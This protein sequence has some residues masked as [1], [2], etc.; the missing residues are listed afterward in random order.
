MGKTILCVDDSVTMQ[1]VC[2]ITFRASDFDYVGARSAAEALDKARAAKP[3]LALVDNVMPDQSG[4]ELCEALK[5]EHPD[6]PVVL[7]CGNSE[8][9]DDV[10]GRRAGVDGHVTKPWDTT[11]LLEQIGEILERVARDGVARPGEDAAAPAATAGAPA[12]ASPAVAAS[13]APA[14]P[15]PASPAPAA[16]APP[17]A[18]PKPA[19]PAPAA[20]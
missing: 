15:K 7:M 9:Y 3:A 20:S 4:Y 10:R 2:E 6:V 1:T 19:S 11:K 16:S 13:P 17:P 18:A 14:A 8:A 12:G 5:R